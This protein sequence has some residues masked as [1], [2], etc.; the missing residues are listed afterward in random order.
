MPTFVVLERII[1]AYLFNKR[2]YIHAFEALQY[3]HAYMHSYIWAELYFDTL[4]PV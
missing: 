2:T 3:A 1:N 4:Y